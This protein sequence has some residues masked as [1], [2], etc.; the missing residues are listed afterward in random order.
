MQYDR[1]I[2]K[3]TLCF[4]CW[5][6][7]GVLT[8]VDDGKVI[9][10]TG[11]PGHPVNQGWI[12]ERSKAFIEHLY[13]EDRLNYPLKRLGERGAG[14]WQRLSWDEALNEV[15]EKLDRI[16]TQSGAEAVAS[17]GGTGRGFS[18]LFKV[19]FMNLFGSPNHA[20]A[21][22]W[23][24]VVSRQ[25]HAAI[26]GAGASRAVKPPCKCAVIWGGNPAEAFACVFPQHIKAK[27]ARKSNHMWSPNNG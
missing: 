14:N 1:S 2:I 4:G 19:R 26:Y 18:E 5:L 6:Q 17:I 21:G 3:R 16:R 27:R 24:S 25:I 13:H 20:N 11:E 9:K 15:A 10:L 22:Q 12:C 23:C 8:T 7:A